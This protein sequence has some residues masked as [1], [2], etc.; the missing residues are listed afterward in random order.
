ML[1][2]NRMVY[3]AVI[4]AIAGVAL[5]FRVPQ[6]T[7]RPM[8]GDEANQAV[9][10]GILYDKG[11]YHYD[12]FEHHGPTL[13]FLTQP[14]IWISGAKSFADTNEWTYRIVPVCFGTAL[15]LLVGFFARGLGRW[16]TLW[17]ML[18]T[19]VSH[20]MVYYS[21]YY[22]HEILLVFF[23]MGFIHAG[24]RYTQTKGLRWAI[25][26]GLWLGLMHATKE[27]TLL[28]VA[29]MAVALTA[30]L[31]IARMREGSRFPW[32]EHIR[33]S[34]VAAGLLVAAAVSVLFF[35][36]FFSYARGPL[37]SILTYASYFHRAEGQGS[38]GLHDK[39]WYYY[40]SILGY[41][42][43]SAGP[44]WS[45]AIILGLGSV[46]VIVS[47]CK[48]AVPPEANADVPNVHFMRF[49]AI[50]TVLLTVAFSIIPYKT[51]WNALVFFQPMILMAGVGAVSVVRAGRWLPVKGVLIV[52]LLLGTAQLAHQSWLGNF[53]YPADP[54]N[55]YAYAHTSTAL[56]RLVS[57]FEEIAAV[58]PEGKHMQINIVL[59]SGDYWPLPWYLRN[60]DRVGYWRQCPENADAPMIIT[61]PRQ[62]KELDQHLKEKYQIE[63]HA[64]RPGVLLRAY[65]RQDLWDA[66]IKTRS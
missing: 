35:S 11:V 54:R 38:S 25:A 21:R 49:L 46:G 61:D 26:A 22:V 60:F 5:A 56:M 52:L 45:E 30:A 39:P 55:P 51:P 63:Y 24:W 15:V 3:A 2:R 53:R 18:F 29:V 28:I 42:Y 64:I 14:S 20:A 19:A 16:P 13:Y 12:P 33:C 10:A 7:M 27:T 32:R 8:H 47:L 43:H 23:T 31:L 59:P 40:L 37:D 57:R 9:K 41:T 58:S 66:F 6:L 4:L 34:H 65:I 36:S 44:R 50:Y 62:Q 1:V 17:A 48:R